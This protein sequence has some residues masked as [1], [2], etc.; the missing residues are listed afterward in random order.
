MHDKTLF[1]DNQL[2]YFQLLLLD[3]HWLK[4]YLKHN[5]NLIN[6]NLAFSSL[7]LQLKK[8]TFKP[9]TVNIQSH[10]TAIKII[11]P[12]TS[13]PTSSLT[14]NFTKT[15]HGNSSQPYTIPQPKTMCPLAHQ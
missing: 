13:V 8:T 15:S 3:Y 10:P 12:K 11:R 9:V 14:A 2:L 4:R 7:Q 1:H 6:L 5:Y